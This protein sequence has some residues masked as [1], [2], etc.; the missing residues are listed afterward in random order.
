MVLF[1]YIGITD[2]T[3]LA[4]FISVRHFQLST[5]KV[6]G[7]VREMKTMLW[8]IVQALQRSF[9][10]YTLQYRSSLYVHYLLHNRVINPGRKS[11]R[12]KETERGRARKTAPLPQ[13]LSL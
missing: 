11:E 9:L 1:A 12:E 2:T 8:K 13:G 3:L 5:V 10:K 6:H 4:L 7:E